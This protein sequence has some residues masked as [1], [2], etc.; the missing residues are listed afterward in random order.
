MEKALQRTGLLL[1]MTKHYDVIIIGAGVIGL[2]TGLKLLERSP[3]LK[4]AILDKEEDVGKHQTGHNS[5]VIHQGI[6]YKPGSLKAQNCLKGVKELLKFCD[7]YQISYEKCGKVIVAATKEEIPRLDELERRGK[8]NGVEGLERIGKERL[9]EIEPAAFGIE[10]LYSP[11]TAI[12]DF[13]AVAKKYAQILSNKGAEIFLDSKVTRIRTAGKEI[14]LTTSEREFHS[15]FIINCA[16]YYADKIAHES[17]RDISRKQIIPFRGEYYKLVE[18]KNGLVKGLIYPVPDPSLPFLGVHVTKMIDGSVEAG[19]NAV[20][21][22]DREGYQKTSIS[23]QQIWDLATYP[24]FWKM[25]MRYW[26]VGCY[27]LYRSYNKGAF[28]KDIQRLVPSIQ[29]KDLLPGESGVRSQVVGNDG[30]ICDDFAIIQR[31]G[32]IHVLSAPSPG[33]TASLA[34]GKHIASLYPL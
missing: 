13:V 3:R 34:I 2:A 30:S 11:N 12:T 6:Y 24:G 21:A 31:P 1:E 25:A 23:M 27:E 28:V 33:A 7:E 29:A 9:K 5:G 22:L 4:V 10:A 15:S 19:P 18:E 8:A 26:K 14:V 16:G 32:M 20:L 17:S